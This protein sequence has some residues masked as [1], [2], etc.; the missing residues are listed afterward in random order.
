MYLLCWSQQ[1]SSMWTTQQGHEWVGAWMRF[2]I[3]VIYFA[4]IYMQSHIASLPKLAIVVTLTV[5]FDET[6]SPKG[7]ILT[8]YNKTRL[9]VASVSWHLITKAGVI[10]NMLAICYCCMLDCTFP[11]TEQK[12]R[13]VMKSITTVPKI[14]FTLINRYTI[15]LWYQHFYFALF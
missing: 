5:D 4:V 14:L 13:H 11:C 15:S 12:C 2:Y 9:N 8:T 1:C 6:L 3:G 10:W 7:W